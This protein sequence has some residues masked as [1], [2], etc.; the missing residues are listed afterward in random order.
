MATVFNSFKFLVDEM[1]FM[2][3]RTLWHYI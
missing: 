3:S 2:G 1:F